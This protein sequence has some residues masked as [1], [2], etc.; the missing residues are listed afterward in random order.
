M[1][2]IVL[3]MAIVALTGCSSIKKYWP[4]THDPVLFDHLVAVDIAVEQVDCDKA[5]WNKHKLIKEAI[6]AR[7]KK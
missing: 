7:E 1:K 5:D 2:K 3:L 4:R 6:D